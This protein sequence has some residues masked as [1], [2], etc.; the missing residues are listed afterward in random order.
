MLLN[1]LKT[2]IRALLK[3]RGYTAINLLGLTLGLT[4]GIL[5]LVYV[6]D[7]LSFDKFHTHADRIYRVGTDMRDITSGNSTGSIETNGWPIGALLERD[8]PEVEKVVYISNGSNLQINHAEKRFEE[9]I[10]YAGQEFFEI[11]TFPFVQGNPATALSKPNSIV[12]TESMQQKYFN[13]ESALGKT[14]VFSDTLLMEVTG[15]IKDVPKQSHMQFSI[16]VSF[17]TYESLNKWFSYD[18]GWGNLNVRNYILLKKDVDKNAFFVKSRNLYMNYVKEEMMKWGMLMYVEHEPL[19][20]IYLHTRFGNG[21]GPLGSIDRIYIV[22]GIA[23]FVILLACINFINLATARSVYRAKE[24]GLRKVVGSTRGS[25]IRQFLSESF[26]LTV[27]SFIIAVAL[28]GIVLPLFNQ[29]LDKTYDLSDFT[30]PTLV[31][32]SAALIIL[33]TFLSGYYPALVMTSMKPS[34][35]LKSSVKSGTRG[36]QLR[37]VLVVFQFMI[38]TTL[39]ICTLT[40]VDQL[41][42]MQNRDLGFSGKQILVLDMG[43]VENP[44]NNNAQNNNPFTV[45]ENEL[46]AMATIDAV[47][48]TNALPGRPGWVGQWAFPEDNPDAGSIG[49]EYMTID[50]NYLRTLE[51]TLLAGRNFDLDRTAELEDGLIINETA[52]QKL[53]WS[54][55]ENAIGK[56]IDSPSKHPAGVVIGVVKDYHQFG[57]QQSIYPMAMDYNPARSRYFAIRFNTTGTDDLLVQLGKL[58]KKNFDGYD[59]KY[60]FLDENFARAYQAEQRLAKIFKVFSVVTMLIAIIGLIGLVSFMVV[61]RTKEIGIRKILGADVTHITRLLSKEFLALVFI[62]NLIACPLAWYATNQWLEGFAYRTVVGIDLFVITFMVAIGTTFVTVGIHTVR[63]AL[64]DPVKSLR[65][66]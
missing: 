42:F 50:E 31:L 10:F 12:I 4:S 20:D 28:I 14:I 53:G 57:L 36:I 40:V 25:L 34:E 41:D 23:L 7:E 2:A 11:F 47:T 13:Q 35:V 24:V 18:G 30:Q 61:S 17:V 44:E 6:I 43:R 1:Y 62:A 65:Y 59:F 63:A 55:P 49:M 64:T 60:F 32:G 38:S 27:L 16:L 45:F 5:I 54:T 52:V 66:E 51:I 29:L 58:W 33:I 19:E 9:R 37:R 48:F 15:V 56:R 21:M 8:F 46:K 39:L 22:S 3:F 26:L